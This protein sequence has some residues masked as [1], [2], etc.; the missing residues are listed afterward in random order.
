MK[1]ISYWYPYQKAEESEL[2]L[3]HIASLHNPQRS[4]NQ[5]Y[6]KTY[7]KKK[8]IIAMIK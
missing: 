1:Q 6:D 7:L 4:A 3:A 5:S 2:P 8:F